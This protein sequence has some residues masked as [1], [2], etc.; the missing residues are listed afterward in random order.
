MTKYIAFLR[1]INVGKIRIKMTDLKLAF[2]DIG[3]EDVKTYLQTG[4]VVFQSGKALS[5]LKLLIEKGL[6]DTFKYE[7]YVLLY[8]FDVLSDIITRY[9]MERDEKHHA[10]VIFIDKPAIFEELKTLAGGLVDEADLIKSGDQILYWKV[11]VGS[12]LDTPF[13]KISAKAKYKS[14]VTVRNLNTLE[15]MV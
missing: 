5:D 8:E 14:S 13:S 15:K 3:C 2:E 4:N 9:P 1:G 10:Y 12:S 6:S 7:A 11:P